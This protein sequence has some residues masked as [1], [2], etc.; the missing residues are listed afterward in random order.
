M[1]G[2]T[3]ANMWDVITAQ[4]P[5]FSVAAVLLILVGLFAAYKSKPGAAIPDQKNGWTPTGRIDF[6]DPASNGFFILQVEDT[7]IVD[8]IG[9]VEHREIRWRCATLDEVK[10]V[11]VAYH[12]Q[13]NLAMAA[14]YIVSSRAPIRRNSDLDNAHQIA[15]PEKAAA[16]EGNVPR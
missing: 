12:A 5:W 9:G 15:Q 4:W 7:R 8:S 13:R 16:P 11:V 1:L 14:N 2:E 10:S 6:S 3:I